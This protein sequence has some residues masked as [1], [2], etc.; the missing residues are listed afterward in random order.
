MRFTRPTTRASDGDAADVGDLVDQAVALLEL[1]RD[2]GVVETLPGVRCD[3]A[4]YRGRLDR[5]A[6]TKAT[7]EAIRR[8]TKAA[9]RAVPEAARVPPAELFDVLNRH[10]CNVYGV[11]GAGN[12]DV[13]H[14]YTIVRHEPPRVA[15]R[16]AQRHEPRERGGRRRVLGHEVPAVNSGARVDEELAVDAEQLR[17]ADE[18][19]EFEEDARFGDRCGSA[20]QQEEHTHHRALSSG[21]ALRTLFRAHAC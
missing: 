11:L 7:G 13:E 4:S 12:A 10:Q 15:R 9:L 20:A 6:R 5:I 8:A 3:Y 14:A 19:A 2:A 17:A 21:N 1:R 18:R 16:R